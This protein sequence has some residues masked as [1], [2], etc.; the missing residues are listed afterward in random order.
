MTMRACASWSVAS[1]NRRGITFCR[2]AAVPK[3]I[4]LLEAGTAIDLLIADLSMPEMGGMETARRIR[5]MRPDL[6]VLY[7]TGFIDGLMNVRSL[8]EGEAFLAKPITADSL[9]E[10]VS[11]LL[12]G[13]TTKPPTS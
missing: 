5:V 12:Y 6:K 10:A 9:R 11:L 7:V 3:A 4:A 1:W 8:W 2:R 13:T